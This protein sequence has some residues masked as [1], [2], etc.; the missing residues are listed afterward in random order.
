MKKKLNEAP[1]EP[2]EYKPIPTYVTLPLDEL[3]ELIARITGEELEIVSERYYYY[4]ALGTSQIE[5]VKD[6][7]K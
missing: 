6:F 2:T 3:L 5:C 7:L 4:R 1:S